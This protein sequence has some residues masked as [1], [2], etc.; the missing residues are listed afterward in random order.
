[1]HGVQ[2]KYKNKNVGC[3]WCGEDKNKSGEPGVYEMRSW[4]AVPEY[5]QSQDHL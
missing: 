4:W 1:M 3:A 2:Q 5:R